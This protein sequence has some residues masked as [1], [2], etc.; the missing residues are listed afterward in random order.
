MAS[1]TVAYLLPTKPIPMMLRLV[2]AAATAGALVACAG[3]TATSDTAS[4]PTRAAAVRGGDTAVNAL[5][6]ELERA[7]ERYS[8]AQ[9]RTGGDDEAAQANSKAA[10]DALRA[11][12][13]RC[14]A[15]RGCDSGRFL[16]AYDSLLRGDGGDA[17]VAAEQSV[18]DAV[19]ETLSD[20]DEASPVLAAMPEMERT[21]TLLNGRELSELMV[22]NGPV[23][24]AMEQWLSQYRPNLITAWVNY[25]FMRY[26]MWPEYHRAGLPEA[27]LF[28]MM[29][30]ESG[31][32]V[33]AVSRSGAS[34]PLQ[35]MYTTGLRFGLNTADG[36]DQRFDPG[37]STRA[38]AAYVNE[39][40]KIFNGNL[41]LVVAAYNGGEGRMRRLAGGG[42]TSFWNPDIYFALSTETRDYVPRVLAAAWLFLHPE[43]YNL[44]F[45][46]V[47]ARP[48]SITLTQPASL[49]E[50]SVCFG[51]EGGLH[52][53]WFRALRNLNPSLEPHQRQPAGTRLEVPAPL[54]AA[55][56]SKCA[57]GRW[58]TLAADLHSAVLMA[59]PAGKQVASAPSKPVAGQGATRYVV[60]K[61]DNL[62]AIA[63]RHPC[64][65]PADIARINGLR[66][67]HYAL[68]AGQTIELP[69]CSAR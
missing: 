30:Q 8:S 24:N 48:G 32:R 4:R 59:P 67:P 41:E 46:T 10:L 53:G 21:I 14:N 49:T 55:Y 68:R 3:N 11:L 50:L 51:T 1:V 25:Q 58:A 15:M 7:S 64:A 40:L 28:G 54:Q 31:G 35:F 13:A 45:P 29:A 5:Y 66:A 19:K 23:K 9:L 33:H 12:A 18:A 22:L 20:V 56:A 60:R 27:L 44:V 62:V 6:A 34:G 39:Q 63:R 52:D 47:D 36:F 65:K 43:R 42:A 37:L 57:T 2:L 69:A 26:R 38:N 61:G 17:L 16:S